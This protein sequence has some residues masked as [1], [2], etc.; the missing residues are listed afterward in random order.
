[1]RRVDQTRVRVAQTPENRERQEGYM[2]NPLKDPK[3]QKSR[4]TAGVHY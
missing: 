4:R 2:P 3:W 1:M